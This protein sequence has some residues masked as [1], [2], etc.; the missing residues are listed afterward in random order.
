M[1]AY[2]FVTHGPTSLGGV[3][4]GPKYDGSARTLPL[5]KI[6]GYEGT[7]L[8]HS[9][10]RVSGPHP[11]VNRQ[12]HVADRGLGLREPGLG[13]CVSLEGPVYR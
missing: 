2:T 8:G 10:A 13:I 12:S 11:A 7:R 6:L 4:D 3:G 9:A 5:S 1:R